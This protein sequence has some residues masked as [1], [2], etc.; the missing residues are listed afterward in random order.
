MG[1]DLIEAC[2]SSSH[3][4]GVI[5]AKAAPVLRKQLPLDK[6]HLDAVRGLI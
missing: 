3:D 1:R 5:I 4:D 2:Q 6:T